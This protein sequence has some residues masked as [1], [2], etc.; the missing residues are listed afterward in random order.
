[1]DQT[2]REWIPLLGFFFLKL[3]N[4]CD[5]LFAFLYTQTSL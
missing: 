1:M 5:F 3:D 2:I 4:F